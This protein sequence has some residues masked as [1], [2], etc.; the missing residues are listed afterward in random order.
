LKNLKCNYN[1]II[2][3]DENYVYIKSDEELYLLNEDTLKILKCI[4]EYSE[5]VDEN[6]LHKV[7]VNK[8][9]LYEYVDDFL[10]K[11]L[12]IN[13]VENNSIFQKTFLIVCDLKLR[14]LI[15][16]KLKKLRIITP[17]FFLLEEIDKIKELENTVDLA[18][19]ITIYEPIHIYRKLNE[20]FLSKNISWMKCIINNNSIKI[21]P[22]FIP[23]NSCCYECYQTRKISNLESIEAYH[24]YVNVFEKIYEKFIG[25]ITINSS[26]F[27]L[28]SNLCI[29]EIVNYFS[30]NSNCIGQEI[31][32][33]LKNLDIEKHTIL[34]VPNCICSR[35]NKL[36]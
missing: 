28:S 12:L 9:D 10:D 2:K 16:E 29:N 19:V 24:E 6:I 30:N 20:I 17:I 7:N 23:Y 34:K 33:N 36:Y 25:S 4:E 35:A 21:G 15:L 32:L 3:L 27:A 18:F 31:I 13:S 1:S 14:T 8:N 5:D 11:G 22:T 26:V